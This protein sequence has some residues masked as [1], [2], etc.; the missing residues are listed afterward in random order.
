MDLLNRDDIPIKLITGKFGTGKS[1]ACIVAALEAV[2]K[3]K[4]EKI[5]FVRNNV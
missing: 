2:Q 1:M 4:F 5:V 3:G